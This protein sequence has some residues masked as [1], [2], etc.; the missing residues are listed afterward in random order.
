MKRFLICLVVLAMMMCAVPT[1]SAEEDNMIITD[2][3]ITYFDDGFYT[4]T[5]LREE[6]MTAN[7]LARGNFTRTGSKTITGYGTDGSIIWTFTVTGTF[8]VNEGVVSACT[9]AR[10]SHTISSSVWSLQSANAAKTGNQAIGSA[11]FI[12]K[13]LGITV[14]TRDIT[15]T[16]TCDKYGVMS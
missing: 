2:E 14:E 12:R 1:V 13:T 4:V 7:H 9:T 15:C 8:V 6:P 5:T 11:T 10:Y 3:V 16:L